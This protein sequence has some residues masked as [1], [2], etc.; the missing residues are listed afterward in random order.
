MNLVIDVCVV[1]T[2]II[3]L[4]DLRTTHGGRKYISQAAQCST[5]R[6]LENAKRSRGIINMVAAPQS[7]L[8]YALSS[9]SRYVALSHAHARILDLST[10]PTE[11]Y[12]IFNT[13][14]HGILA[15]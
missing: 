6:T 13:Q 9:D 5:D 3:K 2:S 12:M 8:I 11:Y 10:W 7:G 4:W 1:C 15:S 14:H